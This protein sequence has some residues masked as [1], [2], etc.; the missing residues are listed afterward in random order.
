MAHRCLTFDTGFHTR[1]LLRI[2]ATN[3]GTYS[4]SCSIH[5]ANEKSNREAKR[6]KT[7]DSV[8]AEPF[9]WQAFHEFRHADRQTDRRRVSKS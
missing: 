7:D 1:L 4:Q 2:N 5:R 3:V 8:P 6:R 9:A